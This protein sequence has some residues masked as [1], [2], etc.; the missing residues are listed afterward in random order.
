MEDDG[1]SVM[2]LRGL[3]S[4]ADSKTG[5]RPTSGVMHERSSSRMDEEM[6]CG[7]EVNSGLLDGQV[8][9]L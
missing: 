9:Q 1:L 8:R 7:L 2:S 6:A 4:K 3:P 5:E